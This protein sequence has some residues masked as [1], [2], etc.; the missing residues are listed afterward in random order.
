MAGNN[1]V[2]NLTELYNDSLSSHTCAV[3]ASD[4]QENDVK[5]WINRILPPILLLLGTFGNSLSFVVLRRKFMRHT[6]TGF[7]LACLA[8]VDTLVLWL[9][10][11]RH[12]IKIYGN[13]DIRLLDV[14]VCKLQRFLLYFCLDL[15]AW[16]LVAVTVGRFISTRY[17]LRTPKWCSISRAFKVFG[18]LIV[19]VFGKNAHTLWTVDMNLDPK[20]KKYSCNH[21]EDSQYYFFWKKIVPVFVFAVY[22]A[23][24]FTIM[25]TMNSFIIKALN[26]SRKFQGTVCR[27]STKNHLCKHGNDNLPKNGRTVSNGTVSLGTRS[28]IPKTNRQPYKE[29]KQTTIMLLVVSFVYLLLSSP[30]FINL[31]AEPYIKE[32]IKKINCAERQHGEAIRGLIVVIVLNMMYINHAINFLLYCVSGRSFRREVCYTL[33]IKKRHSFTGSRDSTTR[34]HMNSFNSRLD[35]SSLNGSVFSVNK[36]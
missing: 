1:S 24:P 32:Y 19:L 10:L 28:K 17:P 35:G 36:M 31:I 21:F 27:G 9:G 7:F 2:D 30:S 18:I 16:I 34:L 15:S 12:M 14:S 22:A 29:T 8:I 4:Y 5:L 23:G 26:K 3:K 13:Y 33:K 25:I 20:T 11:S 6:W